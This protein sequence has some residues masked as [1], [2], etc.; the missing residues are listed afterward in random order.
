MT[1]RLE[2]GYKG[3][4]AVENAFGLKK[5]KTD[6]PLYFFPKHLLLD[7]CWQKSNGFD[8]PPV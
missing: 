7:I 6:V 8:K 5:S 3:D 2:K 4:R 1:K